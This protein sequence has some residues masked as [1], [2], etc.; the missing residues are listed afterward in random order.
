MAN[1]AKE[2]S[3]DLIIIGSGLYV[4]M[5]ERRRREAR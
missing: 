3:F 2:G 5:R 4:A 1:E